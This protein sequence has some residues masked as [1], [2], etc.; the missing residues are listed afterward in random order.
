MN[1]LLR[2]F[3]PGVPEER[4]VPFHQDAMGLPVDFHMVNCWTMLYPEACGGEGP[5]PGL[6]FIPG[7]YAGRLSLQAGS[8]SKLYAGFETDLELIEQQKRIF[9]VVTPRIELGDILMFN[10][11]AMHRTSR[12]GGSER[13][14][15]AEIRLVA[16]NE[17]AAEH[18]AASGHAYAHISME[19][20]EMRWPW[21]WQLRD[22]KIYPLEWKVAPL[23]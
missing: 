22:R 14:M 10:E 21:R 20:R 1:L 15:S 9:G 11:H 7:K 8:T 3:G 13:R 19:R 5:A 12:T 18:E 2:A 16:A 4:Y 6:D 17:C 23:A